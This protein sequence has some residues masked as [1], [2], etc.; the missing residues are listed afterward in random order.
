MLSNKSPAAWQRNVPVDA[1][2]AFGFNVP[3]RRGSA[4]SNIVFTDSNWNAVEFMVVEIENGE[5]LVPVSKLS[6]YTTYTVS[7]SE[8]AY[9]SDGGIINDTF[10]LSFTTVKL[11][12]VGLNNL[13]IPN[14]GVVEKQ[15][16]FDAA[17]VENIAR[18]DGY[19]IESYQWRIDGELVG[20]N[21]YIYHTF[22]TTG[23]H[24]LKLII[25]DNQGN[26]CI[27]E[28]TIKIQPL[29]NVG[30]SFISH[31]EEL[32]TAIVHKDGTILWRNQYELK[33]VHDGQLINGE[34]IGVALYRDNIYHAAFLLHTY[35]NLCITDNF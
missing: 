22:V 24:E 12:D 19:K 23:N 3:V 2:V 25:I 7:I 15:F 31:D 4:H 21:K 5:R 6:S 9:A 10:D 26:T 18:R 20:T 17:E 8:G 1:T 34:E 33:L 13:T 35:L 27:I 16:F 30:M 11:L 28:E 32:T 14:H 29:T